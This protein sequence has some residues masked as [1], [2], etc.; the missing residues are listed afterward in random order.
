MNGITYKFNSDGSI[1]LNGTATDNTSYVQLSDTIA[2]NGTYTLSLVSNDKANIFMRGLNIDNSYSIDLSTN[3]SKRTNTINSRYV[4]Y[5][6]VDKGTTL[7]YV[8]V[9]PQLEKGTLPTSFSSWAGYIEESGSND[10]GNYIKYSDGTMICHKV[11]SG[12]PASLSAW[13]SCYYV[14]VDCGNW[15]Q[16]FTSILNCQATCNVAQYWLA[17]GAVTESSAGSTRIL[18]MDSNARSYKIYLMAIGRWK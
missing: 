12:T 15:P 1:L 9:Y 8:R 10:N 3:Q 13:S 18:C 6:Y 4:F 17:K 5:L 11:V 16:T 7:N 2:L 14:D